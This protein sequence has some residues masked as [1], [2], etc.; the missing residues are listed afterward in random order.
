MEAELLIRILLTVVFGAILGLESET[1]LLEIQ[2]KKALAKH[3]RE[4][5]GG[6]RTYTILSLIGGVCGILYTNGLENFVYVIVTGILLL[7]VSAYILNVQMKKAFGITTELAII[8]TFLIGFFTTTFLIPLGL[9]LVILVLLT[10]FLS[11]RGGFR[12]IL[13]KLKHREIIEIIKFGLVALVVLPLLPNRN[14]TIGDVLNGLNF[15]QEI[16]S[17]L[18]YMK[19]FVLLNP[20]RIWFIVVLISGLNLLGIFLSKFVGKAKGFLATGILGGFISST[21][22]IVSLASQSKSKKSEK[23]SERMLAGAGIASNAVSFIEISLI[24]AVVSS[25]LFLKVAPSLVLMLFI[26][27]VVSVFMLKKS[28]HNSASKNVKHHTHEIE[29]ASFSL[30]PALK[31]VSL[32]LFFTI[33]IQAIELLDLKGLSLFVVSLSGMVGFNISVLT[34]SELVNAGTVALS[35]GIWGI[36]LANAVNFIAKIFYS[37]FMGTRKFTYY[38]ILGLTITFLGSLIMILFIVPY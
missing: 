15:N 10:F 9:V 12:F 25:Q 7:I 20:F 5:I 2:G 8:I 37:G 24:L 1:R 28:R 4:N 26:G 21:A 23:D 32:L 27:L 34:M 30:I 29:N 3:R 38:I 17:A 13:D 19:D 36:F 11:N 31:F 14:F 18:N 35:F 33:I 22:T 16:I 6:I